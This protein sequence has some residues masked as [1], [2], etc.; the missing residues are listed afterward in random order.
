MHIVLMNG[1]NTRFLSSITEVERGAWDRLF[2]SACEGYDYFLSCEQAVPDAFEFY[3]IGVFRG[4]HLIAGSILFRVDMRLDVLLDGVVRSFATQLYNL[5]P[6]ALTIRMIG[7]GSPHAD[8]LPLRFD[9][10]LTEEQREFA[11]TA[12]TDA[13][14]AHAKE[15]R[16]PVVLLKNVTEIQDQWMRPNLLG[17][18]YSRMPSLPIAELE[19]P[20]SE[21][22][23]IQNLSANMRSNIRRKLKKAAGIRVE[24][25]NSAKG[26]NHELIKLRDE[27]RAR[28]KDD[29]EV[30]EELSPRYFSAVLKNG[31]DKAKLL[32]YWHGS[33]LIGFAIALLEPGRL[34]EKYT[35]MHYPDALHHGVFF[36]NWMMMVRLCLENNIPK[37]HAGETTYLTKTRLGC[38]LDRSWIYV[39]YTNG[40]INRLARKIVPLI[41]IDKSDL[42]L[43]LLGDKAPYKNPR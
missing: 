34:K 32:L 38:T 5:F 19:I 4:E 28:A 10:K 12:V 21:E 8:E 25:R 16:V 24:I 42:D 30:F 29:Y 20:N 14:L 9:P 13:M 33:R 35:G 26:I 18:G 43:K 31:G 36:L 22:N 37:F 39:R 1:L 6:R 40:L 17:Q 23:Y 11:L 2:D 41:A 27:T 7:M 15:E 3:A